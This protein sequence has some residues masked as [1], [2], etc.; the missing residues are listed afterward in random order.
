MKVLDQEFDNHATDAKVL[1]MVELRN[2]N[3]QCF[4]ELESYNNTGK[5]LFIHP[6]IIHES[7]YNQLVELRRKNPQEFLRQYVATV[8]NVKRYKSFIKQESRQSKRK[9]DKLHLQAHIDRENIFKSIL[10]NEDTN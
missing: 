2:Q 8:G 6:L 5:W 4:K 10:E 1:R 7:E 3:L 9:T